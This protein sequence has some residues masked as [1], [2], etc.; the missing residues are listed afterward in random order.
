MILTTT[1]KATATTHSQDQFHEEPDEPKHDK[2]CRVL[3]EVEKL[4]SVW[5][6]AFFHQSRGVSHELLQRRDGDVGDF[7][8]IMVVVVVLVARVS[9]YVKRERERE[10]ERENWILSNFGLDFGLEN[11]S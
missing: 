1:Q 7:H 4:S 2:P 6:R 11:A 3:K 5:F 9:F 10:R 8:L